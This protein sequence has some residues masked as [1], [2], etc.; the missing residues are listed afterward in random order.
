[1]LLIITYILKIYYNS[2]VTHLLTE[3]KLFI[4]KN[5]T[6]ISVYPSWLSCFILLG[7]LPHSAEQVPTVWYVISTQQ[8]VLF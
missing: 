1:M 2:G 7:E 3:N 6:K 8:M 5:N 4:G